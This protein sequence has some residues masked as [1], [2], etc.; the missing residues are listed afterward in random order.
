M[1]LI[2]MILQQFD[3]VIILLLSATITIDTVTTDATT[4][5]E[6]TVLLPMLLLQ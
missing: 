2:P 1:V 6:V 5:D 4:T 3:Q